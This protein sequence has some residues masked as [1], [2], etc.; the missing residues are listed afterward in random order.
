MMCWRLLV[1]VEKYQ[2]GYDNA[3]FI[4]IDRQ[5]SVMHPHSTWM[6]HCNHFA[7]CSHFANF[8][9]SYAFASYLTR[10][11]TPRMST[12]TNLWDGQV[13]STLFT[14]SH[15]YCQTRKAWKSTT[16]GAT[17]IAKIIGIPTFL[18]CHERKW[19]THVNREYHLLIFN[20]LLF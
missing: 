4:I 12:K 14:T 16:P 18:G 17:G 5:L 9:S 3:G 8:I 15:F 13:E 1:D 20:N 19:S 11:L 10:I 7:L 2:S 6:W